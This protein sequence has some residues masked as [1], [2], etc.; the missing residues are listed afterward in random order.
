MSE[1]LS[2]FKGIRGDSGLKFDR[3]LRKSDGAVLWKRSTPYYAIQAG[4]LVE[5]P[6]ASAWHGGYA[7]TSGEISN[8]YGA[9]YGGVG[10]PDGD[11][12]SWGADTGNL[13]TKGCKYFSVD[14]FVHNEGDAM[15]AEFIMYGNGNVIHSQWLSATSNKVNKTVD[16]SD[17]QTVRAY[18]ITRDN[19]DENNTWVNVGFAEVR[20]HD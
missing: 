12:D 17:Y 9:F 6:N 8:G 20:L 19:T 13:D 4:K 1:Y 7:C 10:H 18:I 16:I 2:S 15:P 11:G 3:V 14:T 5:C